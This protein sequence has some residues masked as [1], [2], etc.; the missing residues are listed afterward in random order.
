MNVLFCCGRMRLYQYLFWITTRYKVL[1]I[2]KLLKYFEDIVKDLQNFHQSEF[3]R[4]FL[5]RV[6]KAIRNVKFLKF[7]S[8]Y[9]LK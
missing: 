1:N 5:F 3:I 4:I 8:N 2:D 7:R 6:Y 9:V